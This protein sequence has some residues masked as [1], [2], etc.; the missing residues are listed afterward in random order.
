MGEHSPPEVSTGIPRISG[1]LGVIFGLIGGVAQRNSIAADPVAVAARHGRSVTAVA[2]TILRDAVAAEREAAEP[3]LAEVKSRLGARQ[4]EVATA[5]YA[6]AD[7]RPGACARSVR[8]ARADLRLVDRRLRRADRPSHPSLLR[9]ARP[10]RR[11]ADAP[12]SAL[13]SRPHAVVRLYRTARDVHPLIAGA[14]GA[15]GPTPR[16]VA[17]QSDSGSFRLL[18]PRG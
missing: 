11:R 16:D 4:I 8:S 2:R 1:L 7:A 17:P 9:Q 5:F 14:G 12:S 15:I 18:S 3:N 10:P 13:L 6:R